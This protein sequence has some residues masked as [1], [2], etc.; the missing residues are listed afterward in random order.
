RQDFQRDLVRHRRRREKERT[1]VA[2]Q[3]RRAALQLVH[4]RVLAHLLV[5]DL[6]GGHRSAHLGSRLR[7][8]VR[9]EVDH[10][11]ILPITPRLPRVM[12]LKRDPRVRRG[13]R[14]LDRKS[15]RLNSSHV[16]ISY[17]V[18]CLKKKKQT[19]S[20]SVASSTT[21]L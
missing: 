18:F 12:S 5:A 15:T 1:L 20:A 8:R 3:L 21:E 11:A 16:A 13:L 17:A 10:A 7:R 2:E 9:T 14:V 6:G 19:A 4:R